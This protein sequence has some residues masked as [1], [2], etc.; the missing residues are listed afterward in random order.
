MPWGREATR[1]A[2]RAVAPSTPARHA[3]TKAGD[4]A[5]DGIGL[6]LGLGDRFGVQ[7]LLGSSVFALV[8]G[9][10]RAPTQGDTMKDHERTEALTSWQADAR[11]VTEGLAAVD[12]RAFLM[13]S[14]VTGAAAVLAGCAAPTPEQTASNPTPPPAPKV[15]ASQ[16]SQD[17]AVKKDTKGPVM[18]TIDEFYKVGPG[19]SSSHTIGPMRIT[20]DFYQR[21]T[22]LPADQLAKATALKVH[23][24]GSL[25]ATGKGHGTE[26][27]SLAG[28]VGK[29]PA[30][31]EPAF[32]DGLASNPDQ[33]FDVSLG[34]KTFKASL[35]DIIYDAPKGEFPHPNTMTCKLMAGDQV[36]LEQEYYSVGGGFIEWKGYEPPKKGQP[37]YPYSTMKELLSHAETN[38]LSVAQVVMAN[39]IAVSGKTEAEIGAFVHK[40]HTAMVNIVKAGLAAPESTLP[41]PIKLKTKAGDVYKRAQDE[42]YIGQRGVGVV[43]AYALAGSEEN[44]RGHLVV[45]APTGGSAGVMPAIV[46]AIGEGGRNLPDDKIRDGFLAAAAIGYLCKHNA[47]LSGA[48]GG[49]Q[50]EIG[51]ASAM[52]AAF[53]AQAHDQPPQVVANAAESSLQHHLGM[54]CDPV[55]GFVQVPCIE[56]CAFGAVKAWTG[57]M[58]ASNEIPANRRVDFDTTVTAMALTAREMNGKYKETSEGGLAVSLALC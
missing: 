21:C 29:E 24:F 54:T 51:V 5:G 30:T 26:R 23:L 36:L 58:I 45:T 15:A 50:A 55:A 39:E 4:R 47:T 28:I 7:L 6:H 32:L 14:A 42:K 22:K 3:A 43:A 40:I 56:R 46:Y 18:T 9:V 41:G 31:V 44:A 48:E 1:A 10:N 11:A 38:K 17:L 12:R 37:K 2:R 19:P 13:R 35:K 25:S 27:A 53:L 57:F 8:G 49:C 16:V 34:G 33:T 52:G 20:Y